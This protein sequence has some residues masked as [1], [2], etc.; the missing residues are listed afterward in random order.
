M[1]MRWYA[2]VGAHALTM[3]RASNSVLFPEY[4]KL[5]VFYFEVGVFPTVA[6]LQ[7]TW[8]QC[9]SGCSPRRFSLAQ[10]HQRK[11]EHSPSTSRQDPRENMSKSEKPSGKGYV[12][13]I[14]EPIQLNAQLSQTSHSADP[15]RLCLGDGRKES[16]F[17]GVFHVKTVHFIM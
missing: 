2:E 4:A 13:T 8:C 9:D 16:A 17:K 7:M 6:L 15:S 11:L 1:E 12:E 10:F 14:L 3:N 5:G